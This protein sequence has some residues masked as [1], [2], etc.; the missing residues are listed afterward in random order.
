MANT[1]FKMN[2]ARER[3]ST[4]V[5]PA[6]TLLHQLV[7]NAARDV[8]SSLELGTGERTMQEFFRVGS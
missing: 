2:R 8:G 6:L 7:V 5:T 4:S 1:S 3:R